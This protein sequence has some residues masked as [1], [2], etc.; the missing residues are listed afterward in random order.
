MDFRKSPHVTTAP[1]LV[2]V[3]SSLFRFLAGYRKHFAFYLLLIF[4]LAGGLAAS[5][6]EGQEPSTN[7][8]VVTNVDTSPHFNV[9]TYVVHDNGLLP[10]NVWGPLLAKHTGAN[11]SLTEI[12]KATFD[13]QEQYREHGNPK[14]SIAMAHEQITNGVVTLN[15]F[16]AAVPQVVVSGIRYNSPTNATAPLIVPAM[17]SAPIYQM[18]TNAAP[19][20][21]AVT[22]FTEPVVPAKPA[23]AAGIAA[24]RAA[25]AKEEFKLDTTVP[26]TRIHVASTNAGPRFSV[27]HYIIKGNTVLSPHSIAQVLTN[28]DGAFGTNVSFDG[29]KAVVS[30]LGKAYH[31]RGYATVAVDVPRQKITNATVKLQ[32]LEGR[33]AAITVSGNHYFSSNN[34][35]RALPSLHTNMVLNVPV[36]NAEL[37]RAN[38]NQDRTIYPLIGPGPEPGTSD[39]N[40][41]VKDRLPLHAKIEL[42]NEN[43]PGSPALRINSSA[44]YD[45]LWQM[46]HSFGVQYGF[47]PQM[48]KP[49]DDWPFYDLPAVA[50][51]SAFYR[52]PLGNPSPI[53]NQI[54]TSAGS[55][56]YNEAT[57]KFILPP[58]TGQPDLTF[59]ASR[60]TDDTGLSTTFS[61]LITP[62]GQNPS[63][64]QQDV[65]T[66]PEVNQDIGTRMSLPLPATSDFQS[67]LSIGLDFKTYDISNYKTNVFTYTQ[68]NFNTGGQP[69]LPPVVSVDYSAIPATVS[70]IEYL[71]VSLRYDG[72]LNT[73]AGTTAFGLGLM[74]NPWFSSRT[75]V[76]TGTN[77]NSFGGTASLVQITGSAQSTGYWVALTPSLSQTF[78]SSSLWTTTVRANGQWASQPLISPE[79]FGIGGVNSVRGYHEGEAFGDN[80]WFTSIEEQTPPHIVGTVYGGQP[81]TIQGSL[82]MGGAVAYLADSQ[83]GQQANTKLWGTGFGVTA[84]VGSHWQ[85]QFLFSIP[86]ISTSDVQR[87]DPY[88]NFA[89]TASF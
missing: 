7:S 87:Y 36:F 43:T 79:Q 54:T 70:S 60:S 88:F 66:S 6:A 1:V 31:D 48:M 86:L 62:I 40:L 32:V 59:F 44:V 10:T 76:G 11:V 24:A 35:M 78:V 17:A 53:E 46:E 72:S 89:L 83:P 68:T 75:T 12:V 39:L 14:A 30:E 25:L 65:E 15:V 69:I 82:Y 34:V 28:I 63:I 64:S 2:A 55:F 80:G 61:G 45:N 9:S 51:Y 52:L 13:L 77:A 26:D 23:T 16:Q 22:S 41:Q 42:N 57:R 56:G 74:F 71:P 85:A 38:A 8:T 19:S 49:G 5:F 67:T 4:F 73:A 20:A 21:P 84:G 47:S 33:L 27:E 50:N 58:S 18:T 29:I 37:N 81:L 3:V